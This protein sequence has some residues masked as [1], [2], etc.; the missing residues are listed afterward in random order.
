MPK[1]LTKEQV[2][3]FGEDGYL[4]PIRV[5]SED[6]AAHYLQCL[7]AFEAK[8][9]DDIP[10]L[11]LKAH[12][13]CPWVNEIAHHSTIL[14]IFEDLIGPDLLFSN[15]TF[16]TKEVGSETFADWHQDAYYLRISPKLDVASLA[17]TRHSVESG[18]LRVIPGTHR[19]PLLPHVTR[20]DDA[21]NMLQ[22]RQ[23][24]TDGIDEAEAV[25][26][27]LEPGEISIHTDRLAHSSKPNRARYRRVSMTL[28]YLPTHGYQTSG[29]RDSA[30]LVRGVDTYHHLDVDPSP[31]REMA[32]EALAAWQRAVDVQTETIYE[33]AT[34][35]PQVYR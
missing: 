20:E 28:D 23:H 33:G 13:I 8:Y 16:R 21:H 6:E 17:L 18:C 9:P 26:V 35:T 32:P 19:R 4:A 11:D 24:I 34:M 27:L 15:A 31:G 12:L 22:R 2:E 5:L 10:K 3:R 14:D 7:E 1:F 30:M 29:R 25:D